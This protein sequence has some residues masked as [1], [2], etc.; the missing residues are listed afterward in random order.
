MYKNVL[1][2]IYNAKSIIS[3]SLW[4]DPGFIMIEA[5]SLNM[6]ILTLIAQMVQK[7]LLVMMRMVLSLIQIMKKVLK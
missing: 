6:P 7:N 4:E 5:A 2:Y 3:C 1:N